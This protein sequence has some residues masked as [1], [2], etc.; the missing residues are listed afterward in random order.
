MD[1][2]LRY[3]QLK[4][5]KGILNELDTLREKIKK[6]NGTMITIWHN[7]IFSNKKQNW[8]KI[9]TDFF[10]QKDDKNL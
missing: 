6:V 2:T 4:S 1:A 8:L 9:F 10:E 3:H 5:E 7:D